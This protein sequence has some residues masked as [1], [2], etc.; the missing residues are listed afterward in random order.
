MGFMKR[1]WQVGPAAAGAFSAG[2]LTG[3]LRYEYVHW[4]IHFRAPRSERQRVLR[5]H[6]LSHH[7]CDPNAYFGVTT[8]FFDRLFGSLPRHHR[9][10]YE[11]VID[12]PPLRGESN[13]GTIWPRRA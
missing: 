10:D 6:H 12:R 11:R 3:F 4:R 9:S 2:L 7:F 13:F 8:R 1:P 5:A